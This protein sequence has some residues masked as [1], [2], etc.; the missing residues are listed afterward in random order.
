MTISLREITMK[1]F[2]ECITLSLTE[3]QTHFVASNMYSLAEAKADN[4]SCPFA[5]YADEQMVGFIM[6][7]FDE[8]NETL[9]I[10]R[11]MVDKRFQGNGYGKQAMKMVVDEYMNHDKCRILRTSFVPQNSG[12][13][14]AYES[15]GF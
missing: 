5:I 8:A 13:K 7:W 1:N 6:Y 14:K 4:V 11:L 9:W 3:E 15:L 12:A 2:H 10:D